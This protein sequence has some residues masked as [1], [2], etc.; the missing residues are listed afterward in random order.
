[1]N[2]ND[3]GYTY[4]YEAIEKC[5]IFTI[6]ISSISIVFPLSVVV[7]LIQR[8][9]NLVRGKSM[10]H[11]ILMIAIA[12]TFTSFFISLG[13]P[14]PG[15]VCSIQ[16]LSYCILNCNLFI[17]ITL[18]VTI[19]NIT[20]ITAERFYTTTTSTTYKNITRFFFFLLCSYE[21]V[22]YRCT[23]LSIVLYCSIST[24]LFECDIYA[25]HRMVFEYNSSIFTI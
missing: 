11:Y 16:G 20:I 9:D 19:V 6:I 2:G 23:D 22:L 24:V 14:P 15:I 25:Y 10:M 7:I 4:D 17:I 3:D 5:R 1:M 8:F 21:L 13:Y 12:D 18:A